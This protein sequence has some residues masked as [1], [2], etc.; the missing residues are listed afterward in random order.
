VA[1]T[2]F[3]FPWSQVIL[4][5]L[6]LHT[7]TVPPI[8]VAYVAAP[9]LAVALSVISVVAYWAMNEVGAGALVLWCWAGALERGLGRL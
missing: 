7:L 5:L 8:M 3:P 6:L 4:L 9:W 2:P 1:D